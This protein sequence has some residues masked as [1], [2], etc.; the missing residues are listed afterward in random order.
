VSTLVFALKEIAASMR[1]TY[2]SIYRLCTSIE[3]PAAPPIGVRRDRNKPVLKLYRYATARSFFLLSSLFTA[4]GDVHLRLHSAILHKGFSDTNPH[5]PNTVAFAFAPAAELEARD[6]LFQY[7]CP[8]THVLL[9]QAIQRLSTIP[10]Q[11]IDLLL[12][13]L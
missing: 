4:F 2:L 9:S 5:A 8:G 6:R 3:Y 7:P 1:R 12:T 10:Q 13:S 11:P